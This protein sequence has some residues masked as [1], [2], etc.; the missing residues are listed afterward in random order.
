MYKGE[1]RNRV[2]TNLLA[3]LIPF[4]WKTDG[5]AFSLLLSVRILES[6]LPAGQILLTQQLVDAVARLVGGDASQ[7]RL[8]AM[9][10][11]LQ[12]LAFAV[13]QWI[14]AVSQVWLLKLKQKVQYKADL[15]IAEKCQKL[16]FIYYEDPSY[17][18]R[19]QR[20][21]QGMAGRGLNIL[22][23]LFQL[24]QGFVTIFSLVF[25]LVDL[26]P[27]LGIGIV[28]LTVPG[29]LVQ[30]RLGKLRYRQLLGQTATNRRMNDLMRLITRRESAKEMKLFGLYAYMTEKWSRY[31]WKNA[32][33][34]KELEKSG[35]FFVMY[36][37]LLSHLAIVFSAGYLVV[38][39]SQGKL[40]LGQFVALTQAVNTAKNQVSIVA[41]HLANIYESALFANELFDF[42]VLREE[43]TA[44][45]QKTEPL[46]EHQ[47]WAGLTVSG[48]SFRYPGREDWILREVSLR[49]EPGQRVAIVGPN[50]AGKSTLIKCLL[51]LYEPQEG[52]VYW[53]GTPISEIPGYKDKISAVFQDFVHFPLTVRENI[54][55]GH[56]DEMN[57]RSKLEA[58]AAQSGALTVVEKLPSR[59][60]TDLAPEYEGGQELSQGQW[61]KVALGRSFFNTYAEIVVYDEPT[62]ALDPLSEAAL[63]ERFSMLA[64]GK[65]SLMIS[66]RLGSCVRADLIVVMKDGK[67]AEQGTHESLMKQNGDYSR[68]FSAQSRWYRHSGW[69]AKQEHDEKAQ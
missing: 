28:V 57:D 66:H 19:L 35:L 4:I 61:Q 40:L 20:V 60:D 50:G 30:L 51:G 48:V 9:W 2:F 54:G 3:R 63:F 14:K 26:H 11:G 67:I 33:E 68:M 25:L 47:D 31:F 10:L 55:F 27:L 18:D 6:L 8:A 34:Q 39:A 32:N 1:N 49:I 52:C 65:T 7:L 46:P 43:R 21:S 36:A 44:K 62:S 13:Q 64:E 58:A 29:F 24:F 37:E 69:E 38:L 12:T 42:L 45:G 15:L 5:T 16:P 59:F 41:V 17:Y 22:D 56:I 53:N 23:H